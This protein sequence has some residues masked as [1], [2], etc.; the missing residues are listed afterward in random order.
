VNLVAAKIGGNL[1]CEDA[2]F[3][4]KDAAS[5]LDADSAK[6]DGSVF[7]RRGSEVEG[8]VS[9]YSAYVG[10]AFQWFGV[11]SPEKVVV[12]DLRLMKVVTLLNQDSWPK[13]DHL[14]LDGLV[15]DQI[16]YEA[17][18]NAQVQ[19]DW[20]KLQPRGFRS[21][22]FE[23]LAAVLRKMGLEEDAREVMIAKSNEHRRYL[24]APKSRRPWDGVL[25]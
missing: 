22:P 21:Q 6:I 14:N 1:D 20:L 16:A 19:L 15:Y 13:Q 10:R 8:K 7:L 3:F 23:Q 24:P 12:L 17:H 4:S 11:K 5:A 25:G 18:P 2:Q 9:F